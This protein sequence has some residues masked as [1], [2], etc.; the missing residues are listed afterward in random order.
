MRLI[1]VLVVSVIHRENEEQADEEPAQAEVNEA[2]HWKAQL[3]LAIKLCNH[4]HLAPEACFVLISILVQDFVRQLAPIQGTIHELIG[5]SLKALVSECQVYGGDRHELHRECEHHE[6]DK[7]SNDAE[8]LWR[9]VL[10]SDLKDLVAEEVYADLDNAI[11]HADED[12]QQKRG[13]QSSVKEKVV[14][15][16]LFVVRG[17]T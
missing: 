7:Y 6:D 14:I 10:S 4:C 11:K 16:V 13:K 1:V 3:H 5:V 8:G 9:R 2:K 15:K 17:K 12:V